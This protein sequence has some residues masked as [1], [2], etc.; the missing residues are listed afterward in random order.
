M[1]IEAL[2]RSPEDMDYA[3]CWE[4]IMNHLD[5]TRLAAADEAFALYDFGDEVV[6]ESGGWEYIQG[7]GLWRRVVFFENGDN[8]STRRTFVVHFE[9][10]TTEVQESYVE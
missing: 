1:I 7:S 8:P 6:K 10:G 9:E 5:D 3:K 2:P 4:Y